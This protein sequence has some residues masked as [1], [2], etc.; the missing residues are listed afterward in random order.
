MCLSPSPWAFP[1]ILS[2]AFKDMVREGS[3]AI[4]QEDAGV[5]NPFLPPSWK[6]SLTFQTGVHD[7]E[8]EVQSQGPN[9]AS[10]GSSESLHP[11]SPT[12][13]PHSLVLL[14]RFPQIA[15][16]TW[17]LLRTEAGENDPSKDSRRQSLVPDPGLSSFP[18]GEEGCLRLQ[19]STPR[20]SSRAEK[21][22]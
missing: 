20:K 17:W 8:Q 19:P 10:L 7:S 9:T 6:G 14:W 15:P 16:H 5:E 13:V 2:G 12:E 18:A 1:D 3:S 22:V 11:P 4:T 21:V